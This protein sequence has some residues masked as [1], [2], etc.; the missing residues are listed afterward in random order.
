MSRLKMTYIA[1]EWD[2]DFDAVK[3]LYVWNEGKKWN[4]HFKDAHEEKQSRDSSLNCTIKRSLYERLKISKRFILIVGNNTKTARAGSC[5]YCMYYN[6]DMYECKKGYSVDY[7]S[8][9]QYECDKAIEL[10][11]PILVLYNYL[12]V[13]KDKCPDVIKSNGTHMPMCKRNIYND[14]VYDYQ[15][16]NDAI[17]AM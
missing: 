16:V 15:S 7:R 11:I 1:A 9:I 10:G 17:N 2:G 4:L 13:H 6:A 5:Q 14:I 3:Q 12:A 8:Y